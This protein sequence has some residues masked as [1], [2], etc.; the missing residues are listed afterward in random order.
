M[1][2][3]ANS[4][5][6]SPVLA[7]TL[8]SLATALGAT[9]ARNPILVGGVTAFVVALGY[10]SANALWYQPYQHPKPLIETRIMVKAEAPVPSQ[11]PREEPV[12]AVLPP[13][14]DV[15]ASVP[16]PAPAPAPAAGDP[17]VRKVQETLARL[18]LYDGDVDG[19][20][21]PLTKQ[22]IAAYQKTIGLAVDGEISDALL[23]QIEGPLAEKKIAALPAP[24]PRPK[25]RHAAPVEDGSAQLGD[26]DIVKIQAGL[27]AFGH[28]GIDLDGIVGDQTSSAIREFQSLFGLPVTGQPDAQLLVKMTE[29][30]LTN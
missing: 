8:G 24:A 2:R 22:A 21:G 26:A 3:S 30:G 13:S 10:V 16:A 20:S 25:S 12:A 11:T 18:N 27:R 14:P 15:T 7:D 5:R 9:V 29:I 19:L 28:D 23:H 4:R 1:T 17:V 6:K